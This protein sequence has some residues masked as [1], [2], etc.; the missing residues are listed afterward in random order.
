MNATA[1]Q[2]YII[3][4]QSVFRLGKWQRQTSN[5]AKPGTEE[6]EYGQ[7]SVADDRQKEYKYSLIAVEST[8]EA[9]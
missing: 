1:A 4:V 5:Q 6:D 3:Y 9:K 7:K 8:E 2:N